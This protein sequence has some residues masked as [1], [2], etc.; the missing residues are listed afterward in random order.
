MKRESA[1]I[2]ICCLKSQNNNN[3]SGEVSTRLG[4]AA[5]AQLFGFKWQH[6]QGNACKLPRPPPKSTTPIKQCGLRGNQIKCCR[7]RRVASTGVHGH[8]LMP[9]C[10]EQSQP[11]HGRQKAGRLFLCWKTIRARFSFFPDPLSV[12][13]TL[14]GGSFSPTP[15]A[16][17]LSN[18][19]RVGQ[20]NNDSCLAITG[21][22]TPG[23]L[24]KPW[25][26]GLKDLAIERSPNGRPSHFSSS[27]SGSLSTNERSNN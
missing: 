2:V 19:A 12:S 26:L 14:I 5:R 3:E 25:P 23:P 1:E 11:I 18:Q 4:S 9:L 6:L 10:C 16:A 21:C 27:S 24:P 20:A 13:S 15:T 22:M 7:G 8:Y 17:A